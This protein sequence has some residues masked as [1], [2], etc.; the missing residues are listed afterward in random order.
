MPWR[1]AMRAAKLMAP[2][3]RFRGRTMALMS[4]LLLP[5]SWSDPQASS[6]QLPSAIGLCA[7]SVSRNPP[8]SFLQGRQNLGHEEVQ[9]PTKMHLP[10]SQIRSG[11]KECLDNG[12]RAH[13]TREI[14]SCRVIYLQA[15]L[16]IKFTPSAR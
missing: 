11:K 12:F 14:Q 6:N 10:M 1:N 13:Y 16:E 5:P 2:H 15:N 9:G 7:M 8:L 3:L 4:S